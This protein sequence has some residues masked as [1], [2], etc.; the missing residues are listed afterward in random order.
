LGEVEGRERAA[1]LRDYLRIV[2]RRQW[3]IL[4]ALLLVPVATL[5]WSLQQ[6]KLYE[7]NAQVLIGRQNLAAQ[8]QGV[9]DPYQN[10]SPDRVLQ[11]Q[12]NLA[13]VPHVAAEVVDSTGYDGSVGDLLSSS[14]V[15]PKANADLLE[16]KV[17]A[18]SADLAQQLATAYANEYRRYRNELDTVALENARK[19][20]QQ[21][22]SELRRELRPEQRRSSDLYQNLVE[23]EQELET[24]QAL[25]ISNASV[26]QRATDAAQV[27]PRPVR[28]AILGVAL[29]LFLGLLLAFLWEALDTRT[30]S[31][32]ELER[33]L[34]LPLL[35]R[36]PA[37]PRRLR[38]LHKLI[39]IERPQ[40][41]GAEAFRLLRLNIEFLNYG[42]KPGAILVTSA[43]RDEGKSTTAAN[44]AVAFARAGSSV[45]L[46]DLDL[47]RPY[48]HRVFGGEPRPGLTDVALGRA[49]L[50][51]ALA[52]IY[53]SRTPK[54][55]K[56][57]GGSHNGSGSPASAAFHLLA[58]GPL[59]PNPGEF[60]GQ[61]AVAEVIDQLREHF[62]VV[63]IDTPPVLQVGDTMAVA[64]RV[65]ALLLV[66]RL[67]S[68]R[69][70]HMKEL[71]RVLAGAPVSVIGFAVTAAE[72]ESGYGYAPYD[73]EPYDQRKEAAAKDVL[74][75]E[76]RS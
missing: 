60:V 3:V 4:Q 8:L 22:L 32:D 58:A 75:A 34:R 30:R 13:R 42:K 9:P 76:A 70:H 56:L 43:L 55:R 28:D 6:D 54:G 66:A 59:P 44:L 2:K 69:R 39:T 67:Q 41:A 35:G 61:R 1:S 23:R 46:V 29:G 45:A 40:T 14:S 15:S 73:Y 49:R 16:F 18:R 57:R 52:P 10:Q 5:L 36:L 64:P 63:L 68:L 20:L 33:G 72:T 53:V 11:T 62:D 50:D 74:E 37:P 25:Q 12:A 17:R 19:G 48:L 27:A 31:S 71:R 38:R 7:A 21:R 47:R 51:D 65:D 24:L 26:V